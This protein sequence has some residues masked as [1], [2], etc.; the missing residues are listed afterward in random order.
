VE[1]EVGYAEVGG[2]AEVEGATGPQP[3]RPGRLAQQ[4]SEVHRHRAVAAVL[5][6]GHVVDPFPDLVAL[7]L[8]QRAALL[9]PGLD[10][11]LGAEDDGG[12]ASK[13]TSRFGSR[14]GLLWTAPFRSGPHC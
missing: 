12:H 5:V 11:R 9:E 13:G 2:L 7:V 1:A 3:C 8:A 14:K 6:R 10:D 4:G